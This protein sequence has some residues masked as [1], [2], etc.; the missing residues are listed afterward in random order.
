[1]N[2]KKN[3]F[4]NGAKVEETGPPLEGT[5]CGDEGTRYKKFSIYFEIIKISS[6][7]KMKLYLV[8][9]HLE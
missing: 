5:S 3:D 4:R 2:F 7:D 1:M 6:K 9:T 8:N